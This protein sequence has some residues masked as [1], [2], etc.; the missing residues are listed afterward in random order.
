MTLSTSCSRSHCAANRVDSASERGSASMRRTCFSSTAGFLSVDRAAA[1]NELL[2]GDR[3]PQE[4]RQPRREI[5]IADPIR[6]AGSALSPAAARPGTGTAG[7][8][9]C[10]A[11]R[12]GCPTRSRPCA[13]LRVQSHQD[14]EIGRADR[15]AVCLARQPSDDRAAQASCAAA[16]AARS[17]APR[18]VKIRAAA[19]RVR[20]A[21][22]RR[23]PVIVSSRRCGSAVTP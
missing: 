18:Q 12:A 6:L 22:H 9:G 4:E 1:L 8:P 20:H 5:D 23:G 21:G 3:A 7:S 15:L 13:L 2:V 10:P 14:F 19:R 17:P 16:V 11:A